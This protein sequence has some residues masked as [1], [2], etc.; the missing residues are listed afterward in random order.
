M[1]N[2]VCKRAIKKLSNNF[3][4]MEGICSD[5]HDPST[6]L[7]KVQSW[8]GQ[9]DTEPTQLG[10]NY[11]LGTN[12]IQL[13]KFSINWAIRSAIKWLRFT[14]YIKKPYEKCKVE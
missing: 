6:T 7:W 5:L 11:A 12:V 3:Q 2:M 8:A 13:W 4:N 9:V 14:R 10:L 1:K